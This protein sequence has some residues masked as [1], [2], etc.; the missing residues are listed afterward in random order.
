MNK[1]HRRQFGSRLATQFAAQSLIAFGLSFGA[2]SA[3]AQADFPTR[4]I[5]LVIPFAPGGATDILGRMLAA[6]LS[7]KLGQ[8][9]VAENRPGAGAV[10]G[11]SLVANAQPDGYTLLLGA[12]ATLIFNPAIRQNLPY[13]PVKSFTP[14]G[15]MTELNFILLTANTTPA[16]TLKQLVEQAK[17]TPDK[18][19]YGSFGTG[20]GSHFGAE[21]LK[22]TT[23][24]RM[25]HIPYNGSSPNLL[26]LM[27]GQVPV[28]VDT[29][30]A[31]LP[32][33]NAGKMKPIA[34]FS[35]QRLPNLPNV[36]TVAE[37]G[38]P[39][40]DFGSWFAILAPAGLPPTIQSKL[41]KALADVTGTPEMKKK[42]TDIG[43]AFSYGN[44]AATTARI[45]RELPK[46]RAVAARAGIVA[47]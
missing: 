16:S 2:A 47:E 7:E 32:L 22:N 29:V 12:S 1:L 21:L 36:P 13:H 44:A 5:K 4:P 40:F 3:L 8:P 33:I 26:A 34:V 15:M 35:A 24:I 43:L 41:E 28:A 18:Y 39:G 30:V 37:S 9:V 19:S 38:Y 25:L 23:G 42:F 11:S 45:E 17:A 46:M 20:S 31:A 27:S 10:L 6:G 14:I